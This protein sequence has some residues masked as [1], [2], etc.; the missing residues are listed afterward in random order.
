MTKNQEP[1]EKV[2][3]MRWITH[4][5]YTVNEIEFHNDGIGFYFSKIIKT[6]GSSTKTT[7]HWKL[8]HDLKAYQRTQRQK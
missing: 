1:F 7:S 2:P 8:R 4:W 3:F 5:W 6:Y